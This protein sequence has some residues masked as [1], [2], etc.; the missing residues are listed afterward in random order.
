MPCAR[1]ALC[2]R[3]MSVLAPVQRRFLP[4]LDDRIGRHGRLCILERR[5]PGGSAAALQLPAM[6]CA[7]PWWKS[8]LPRDKVWTGMPLSGKVM[9]PSNGWTRSGGTGQQ[10]RPCPGQLGVVRGS[11]RASLRFPFSPAHGRGRCA[12]RHPA[13]VHFD[14]LLFQAVKHGGRVDVMEGRTAE[15]L[16]P[17]IRGWHITLSGPDGA[18]TELDCRM[19]L[20]ASGANSISPACN[21]PPAHGTP[22]PCGGCTGLF[23]GREG[24]GPDGFIE[25]HFLKELPPG[26]LWVFPCPMGMPTSDWG[27]A[28]T[29]VKRR[30]LDLKAE[31]APPASG[32]RH[33]A[34]TFRGCRSGGVR[35]G[36]GPAAGQQAPVDRRRGLPPHRRCRPPDRPFTRRGHQP[37]RRS[38]GVHAAD[39]AA[40]MLARNHLSAMAARPP[41]HGLENGFSGRNFPSAPGCNDLAL[42][43]PGSSTWWWT[44]PRRTRPWPGDRPACSPT[45]TCGR[46]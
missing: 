46:N 26:Y 19:I 35:S 10:G 12:R 14:D 11:R 30:R 28:V 13:R 15:G 31:L 25:L 17:H 37:C 45:S 40:D 1:P 36:H 9:R 22:P 43:R 7:P 27:C 20:D 23:L 41:M 6:G 21:G 34:G 44:A 29:W 33:L 8:A 39:V 16:R 18:R 38:S 42:T 2:W 3:T 4:Q 24:A 5:P 32:T